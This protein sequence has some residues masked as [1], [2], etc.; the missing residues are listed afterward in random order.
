MS[1]DIKRILKE[2]EFFKRENLEMGE[3]G[4]HPTKFISFLLVT[5]FNIFHIDYLDFNNEANFTNR[6]GP[7]LKISPY[8]P[9]SYIMY[10]R[11]EQ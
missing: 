7:W 6:Q 8:Y 1:R 2:T 9:K 4:I 11:E 5:F 10:Y 3:G